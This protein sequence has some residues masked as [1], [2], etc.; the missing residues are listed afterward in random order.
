MI[1]YDS[2]WYDTVTDTASVTA[3]LIAYHLQVLAY[4][5]KF[6]RKF[7]AREHPKNMLQKHSS[8]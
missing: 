5:K 7:T 2:L 1:C 4:V 6:V 3:L 8:Q